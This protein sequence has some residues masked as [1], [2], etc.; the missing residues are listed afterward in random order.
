M[1]AAQFRAEKVTL[2]GCLLIILLS[3]DFFI[4]MRQLGSFF[5]IA[6]NGMAASDKIFHLLDLPMG[7]F[8]AKENLESCVRGRGMT[9]KA[10]MKIMVTATILMSIG[11]IMMCAVPVGRIVLGCV[12]A[13]H[14]AY[15]C[16]GSKPSLYQSTGHNALLCPG[17]IQS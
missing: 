10:K 13:F 6:I 9:R 11:F 7:G 3:A 16:L 17:G 2:A 4:P 14:I 1:A 8:T 12:W 5:H 15:F